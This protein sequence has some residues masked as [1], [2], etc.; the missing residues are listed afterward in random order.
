MG[1]QCHAC[2]GRGIPFIGAG[3]HHAVKTKGH[4]QYADSTKG[5][6]IGDW[7]KIPIAAIGMIT[8]LIMLFRQ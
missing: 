7:D 8:R 4:R 5:K 6:L 1:Y 3:D 2:G